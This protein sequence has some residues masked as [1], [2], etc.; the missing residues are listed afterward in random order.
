MPSFATSA[1]GTRVAYD[2]VGHGPAVVLVDGAFCTR[3]FGPNPKLAEALSDR[4]TVVTYD[5]RGRGDSDDAPRGLDREVEDLAAVIDGAGG[6]AAVYGISSGGGLALE[7]ARRLP[8]IN[9]LAVYEVPFIVDDTRPPLGP[10]FLPRVREAIAE[11]RSGAAVHMFMT[12]GIAQPARMA[13]MMRLMPAWPRL[14]RIAHTVPDDLSI[15]DR[16]QRGRPLDPADW[17]DITVPT[18]V[19]AGG[20]SPA[21]I[22]NAMAALGRVLP[23]AQYRVLDGQTHMVKPK[24]LAPALAGFFGDH[25][26]R[27]VAADPGLPLGAAR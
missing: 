2:R 10:D 7:A 21:W 4:Y 27:A 5:R 16:H 26:P 13:R 11:D 9:A 25:A 23:D 24:V 6:R 12:E 15:V 22:R 1:D 8:G 17:Q 3:D 14:K 20:K 18:L 19:V